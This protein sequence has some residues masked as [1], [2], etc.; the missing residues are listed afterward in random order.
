MTHKAFNY[1]RVTS[2]FI[3]FYTLLGINTYH[4]IK[5]LFARFAK[6]IR[7]CKQTF[8]ILHD[9]KNIST[10]TNYLWELFR[11]CGVKW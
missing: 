2:E 10:Y 4:L 11:F 5:K 7:N 9:V 1:P 3:H 8:L 6:T